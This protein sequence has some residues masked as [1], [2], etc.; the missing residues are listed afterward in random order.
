M[1][2]GSGNAMTVSA[3]I[4]GFH[5]VLALALLTLGAM[6]ISDTLANV[7]VKADPHVATTLAPWDGVIAA[8]AAEAAISAQPTSDEQSE[9]AKLATHALQR[10]PTAVEAL[11]VLGSQAQLRGENELAQR[12]FAQS[13]ALSRRELRAQLWAIEEA[14]SRGDIKGALGHYDIALRTSTRAPDL[15]F[16]TLA[17][18]IEEPRVR[19][20]LLNLLNGKPVWS[21]QFVNYISRGRIK[22]MAS[23]ALLTDRNASEL[24]ID[25]SDRASLVDALASSGNLEDAWEYY[26]SF[27]SKSRQRSRDA[28]F[29]ARIERP[30]VFD[31]NARSSAGISAVIQPTSDGMVFEFSASP[32]VGGT[33]LEQRQFLQSGNY[34]FKATMENINVSRDGAPYWTL[35]CQDGKELWQ[36]PVTSDAEGRVD[37]SRKFTVPSGCLSQNL[38]F[39]VRPSDDIAGVFGR[40]VRATIEP[41]GQ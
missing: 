40:V 27:R 32:S 11:T 22:P 4:R 31:W 13:L 15:L 41:L 8:S 23:V 6:S 12:L 37:I 28:D 21:E 2:K 38:A 5:I 17:S 36:I 26:S 34:T 3:K 14:V 20:A 19:S 1:R 25:D 30:S 24:P 7:V 16:P 9:P 39:V 29:I 10:D 33:V 18:A 35:R